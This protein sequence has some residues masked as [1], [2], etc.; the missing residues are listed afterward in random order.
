VLTDYDHQIKVI[1]DRIDFLKIQDYLGYIRKKE[2]PKLEP[3]TIDFLKEKAEYAL[4]SVLRLSV[5]EIVACDWL[6][7]RHPTEHTL[8][9]HYVVDGWDMMDAK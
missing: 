2:N 4:R 6:A 1:L 3:P 5:F 7:R 8:S 9:L